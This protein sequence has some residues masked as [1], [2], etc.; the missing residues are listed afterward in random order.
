MKAVGVVKC[1][2]VSGDGRHLALGGEDGSLTIVGVP[3]MQTE[4]SIRWV[5]PFGTF[6]ARLDCDAC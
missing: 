2:A 1:M 6:R 3:D 5:I 4:A